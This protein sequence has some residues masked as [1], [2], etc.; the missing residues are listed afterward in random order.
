MNL[1]LRSKSSV[2]IDYSVLKAMTMRY[3]DELDYNDR[4][5]SLL[6]GGKGIVM[7]GKKKHNLFEIIQG[8]KV[9]FFEESGLNKGTVEASE[10]IKAD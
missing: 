8:L 2:F 10:A 4:E 7:N 3:L 6:V 5:V 1:I 9:N